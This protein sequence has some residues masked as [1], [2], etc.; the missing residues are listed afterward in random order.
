[1]VVVLN[2]ANLQYSS[3]HDQSDNRILSGET[4]VSECIWATKRSR[5]GYKPVTDLPQYKKIKGE[6]ASNHIYAREYDNY[7]YEK[8][9]EETFDNGKCIYDAYKYIA[10]NIKYKPETNKTDFWQTPIETDILRMGDCEDAVFL[11]FSRL[12]LN[13]ENAEIVWGWVT[14]K[15]SKERRA[16]VWYQLFDKRGQKYIVEGFS[17]EWNGIIPME[18]A[19]NCEARIPLFSIPHNKVITLVGLLSG[20]DD[21]NGYRALTNLLR[22]M[23]H[24]NTDFENKEYLSK[25]KV[26]F[27]NLNY[28]FIGYPVNNQDKSWNT[29]TPTHRVFPKMR[30]EI[31]NIYK[32]LRKMFLRYDKQKKE[33]SLYAQVSNNTE[34]K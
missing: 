7:L 10:F 32:K 26:R 3:G 20:A 21:R 30:K 27:N 19:R 16:H 25:P 1:M 33:N 15:Q 24:S 6:T 5:L 22:P 12:P 34:L 8:W 23:A 29:A 14:D 2:M 11:F 9:C 18:I 31:F 4:R 28:E 13:Q 17:K